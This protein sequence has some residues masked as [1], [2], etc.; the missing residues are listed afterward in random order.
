M[1][2]GGVVKDKKGKKYALVGKGRLS[3]SIHYRW[4]S[5]HTVS[6]R[7]NDS[8]SRTVRCKL[9]PSEPWPDPPECPIESDNDKGFEEE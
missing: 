2:M 1:L 3:K 5:S 4:T 7:K 6:I 9:Q 8:A